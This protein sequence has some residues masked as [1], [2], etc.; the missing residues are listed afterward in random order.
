MCDVVAVAE[1]RQ[2]DA[3]EIALA[4]AYREQVRERLARVREVR[5]RVDDRD[6]GGA[7][8]HLEPFLF[9]GPDDERVDVSRE[10]AAGV[11]DRLAAAE[12]QLARV[13]HHRVCAELHDRHFERDAGPR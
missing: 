6:V 10:H 11:L 2:H 4:F 8:E 1:V 5:E 9:E 13:Q 12:L 3:G 7:G